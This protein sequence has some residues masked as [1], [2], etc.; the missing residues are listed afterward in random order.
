MATNIHACLVVDT[1]FTW[2]VLDSVGAGV[3]YVYI[4]RVTRFETKTMFNSQSSHASIQLSA[5]IMVR[6]PR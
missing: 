3:L 1:R 4:G 5:T 6:E 2:F